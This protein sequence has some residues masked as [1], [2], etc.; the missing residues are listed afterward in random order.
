MRVILNI[1][2]LQQENAS[3]VNGIFILNVDGLSAGK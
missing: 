2:I 1:P 3:W